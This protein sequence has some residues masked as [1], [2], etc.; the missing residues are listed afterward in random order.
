MADRL[1]CI[2]KAFVNLLIGHFELVIYVSPFQCR[3]LCPGLS[4]LLRLLSSWVGLNFSLSPYETMWSVWLMEASRPKL[5]TNSRPSLSPP[6]LIHL[7][8]PPTTPYIDI[9]RANRLF[10]LPCF[11]ASLHKEGIICWG[12]SRQL[13]LGLQRRGASYEGGLSLSALHDVLLEPQSYG[14]DLWSSLR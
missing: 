4:L 10:P 3:R 14:I 5:L 7:K 1:W 11:S 6:S 8:I 9:E 2:Q 12:G 13:A